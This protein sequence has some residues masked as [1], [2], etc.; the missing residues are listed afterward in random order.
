VLLGREESV[1]RLERLAAFV[2]SRSSQFPE[3]KP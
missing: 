1:A 3:Q 2:T